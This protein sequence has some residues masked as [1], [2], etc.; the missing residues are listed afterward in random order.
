MLFRS[1]Y[2]TAAT[3]LGTVEELPVLYHHG[4]DA[5]IGKRVL[6]RGRLQKDD[7]T[8]NLSPSLVICR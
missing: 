4:Q 8:C 6:G 7:I 1:D 3:E 2:F 5:M